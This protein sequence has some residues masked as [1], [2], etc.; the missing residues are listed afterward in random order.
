VK[1]PASF[2]REEDGTFTIRASF[3]TELARFVKGKAR[4]VTM[5]A[6]FVKE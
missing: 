2:V 4:T 1:V 6:Y 5:S 3:V